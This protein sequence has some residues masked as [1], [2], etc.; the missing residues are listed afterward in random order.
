MLYMLKVK[1]MHTLA[2]IFRHIKKRQW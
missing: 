1:G 2:D